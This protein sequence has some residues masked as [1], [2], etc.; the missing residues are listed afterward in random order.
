MVLTGALLLA[1]CG[2]AET[3]DTSELPDP[4][5][6]SDT[7]PDVEADASRV[8]DTREVL[9]RLRGSVALISTPLGSGSSVLIDGGYLVTNAHVVDPYNEVEVAFEGA[10]PIESVPV[11]G[12]DLVR[13]IA[14]VGPI[15]IDREEQQIVPLGELAQGSDL[16]LVGFPGQQSDMQATISRGVLSRRQAIDDWDLELVHSDATIGSGQSGGAL[17]DDRGRV[18]GISGMRDSNS[19][20]LS[21]N[22]SDVLEAIDLILA[23]D[24]TRWLSVPPEGDTS[25]MDVLVRH[26]GGL[27]VF[28]VSAQERPREVTVH[29]DDPTVAVGVVDAD[30]WVLAG[31]QPLLDGTEAEMLA[32]FRGT[33]ILLTETYLAEAVERAEDGSLTFS[34]EPGW[35]HF[36]VTGSLT[37]GNRYTIETSEPVTH[38]DERLVP[39]TVSL[40]ETRRGWVNSLVSV[41][42]VLVNIDE[43]QSVEIVA[44]SPFSDIAFTLVSPEGIA[45]EAEGE[46]RFWSDDGAGGAF[47]GDDLLEYV[48]TSSG[49][50]AIDVYSLDGAATAYRLEITETG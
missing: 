47:G 4:S 29:V 49:L 41:D 24:G 3:A 7:Q 22:G 46:G 27:E 6:P 40:G 1:A 44:R 26:V 12:V 13:D 32:M 36:V 34:I 33:G 28:H 48:A 9:E 16:Y 21:L 14:V 15:D 18:V 17:V 30:G 23:G 5:Q 2:V 38:L 10:E 20:A 8:L 35:N 25:T 50:H 39:G 19:F 37:Y 31:N 11:V 43:G 45:G 42:R